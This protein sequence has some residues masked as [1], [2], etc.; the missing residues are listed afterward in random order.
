[1]AEGIETNK[2]KEFFLKMNCFLGQGYLFAYPESEEI[3]TNRITQKE[4]EA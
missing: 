4:D 3:A 1:V 2:Q